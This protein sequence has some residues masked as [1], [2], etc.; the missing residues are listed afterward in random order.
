MTFC[1]KGIIENN[2]VHINT[3]TCAHTGTFIPTLLLV[4]VTIAIM[5]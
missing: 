2:K 3:L 4:R 5:K 1:P